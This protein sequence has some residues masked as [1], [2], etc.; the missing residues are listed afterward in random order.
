MSDD[1]AR[2]VGGAQQV[3]A[4]NRLFEQSRDVDA[5][6]P[7]ALLEFAASTGTS[8]GWAPERIDF[9]CDRLNREA[10][11]AAGMDLSKRQYNRRFRALRRIAANAR[12]K[13]GT[14]RES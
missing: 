8:I 12:W 11:D 7:T 13:R 4:T 2:P 9:L 10:R 6:D 1:F 5:D 14:D 3:A